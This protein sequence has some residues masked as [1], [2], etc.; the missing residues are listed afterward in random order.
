MPLDLDQVPDHDVMPDRTDVVVIGGG[1]IGSSTALTLAEKGIAVVLCEKGQVGA[2]QSS[3]NWGWCRTMG[4]DPRELAL[5]IESLRLWREMRQRIGQDTGFRQTGTM[6]L[7]DDARDMAEQAAWLEHGRRYDLDTRLIEGEEVA[8]MLPGARRRF[9]GALYTGSDGCAE[10]QRAAPAIAMAARRRGAIILVGCAVR[11]IETTGGSVSAAITEKGR[12]AC[13]GVVL[14]GG[15]WSRLFCGNLGLDLPQLKVLGSVLRTGPLDG[16]PACAVGAS[17]FGFR[18]RLDG[19]YTAA[20]RGANVSDIVPDSFR[21]LRDFLPA[22]RS[23]WS[24][25]RL[26][27]GRR[28]LDE[29]RLPRRWELDEVTPFEQVRVLDPQPVG[30]ILDEGIANLERAFPVFAK[31][32]VVERWAGLIDVTP[33]AIPVISP[34]ATLAGFFIATGFSGHGFGIGP[35]AGRLMADLVA[36]NHPIVD[37]APFAF[38]RFAARNPRQA[39]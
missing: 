8:Q 19:G 36:G 13:A 29:W 9:A 24:E 11:G 1:I 34:V 30:S 18:K 33:D 28:F 27:L 4:R 17:D 37:P 3:R 32:S 5:G 31:A 26:R 15:A 14:A 39:L 12:I 25:L 22:L 16:P 35:G 38:A 2:E 21:L 10:P 23:Q 7:C 20:R 6:Y